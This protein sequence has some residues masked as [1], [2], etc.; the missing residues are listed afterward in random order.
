MNRFR[1]LNRA[2]S[3]RR[4]LQWGLAAV[5]AAGGLNALADEAPALRAKYGELR[6]ELKRN[7]YHQPIH[8]DSAQEGN[9][10][11]GD[12]Y[13]LLQHPFAQFSGAMKDPADWCDIMILPF[14]TKYCHPT[15]GQNGTGLQVRIG[16]KFDQPV[17]D[18]R[19]L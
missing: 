4:L 18:R 8:I 7:A 19:L 11:R 13:A 6:E 1:F 10:I 2:A 15:E 5:L 17:Q 3:A 14:N 16:R 9:T 12:V